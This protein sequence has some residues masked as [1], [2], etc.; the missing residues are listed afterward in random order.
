MPRFVLDFFEI[1]FLRK[2]IF[3]GVKALSELKPRVFNTKK[4]VQVREEYHAF[5][6]KDLLGIVYIGINITNI[7]LV[8]GRTFLGIK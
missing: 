1:F 7:A 4:V 8:K 3:D 6:Y 2:R 5:S